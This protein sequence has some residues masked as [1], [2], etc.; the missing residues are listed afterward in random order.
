MAIDIAD[1]ITAYGANYVDEG[2]NLARL[3]KKMGL[4][5]KTASLAQSRIIKDTVYRFAKAELDSIVQA[6]QKGFTPKG[7]LTVEPRTIQLFHHK[8][9][10]LVEP[11]DIVESWL[12]FLEN[13]NENDRS[14][15]PLV[16]YIMEVHMAE[17]I[18]DDLE[19]YEYF[20]G[21]YAAPT[22]G[23]APASGT[24]MNGLKKTLDDGITAGRVNQVLLSATPAAANMFDVAEE[25][26]DNIDEEY[27]DVPMYLFMTTA[28]RTNYLRDK[29]NTHG[30]DTN[31]SDSKKLTIDAYENI[32]IVNLPSMSGSTY[33][34]A[35]PKNNY[36][37]IRRQQGF[38]K[39]DVQK[40][41]RQVKILTDWW[42]GLGF[43]LEELV[44]CYDGTNTP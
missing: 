28:A 41:D 30:A 12:G 34:F 42:E 25:F 2:Q 8:V 39:P 10:M 44:W 29:R 43:G 24:A 9:D 36:F 23:V 14:K 13:V 40:V 27:K 20:K 21:V 1:L 18:P 32:E 3:M 11:D 26:V 19:R 15:W 38:K 17:R 6:F 4:K 22:T 37:H 7:D 5:S 35:T 16:R 31:Y 33:M